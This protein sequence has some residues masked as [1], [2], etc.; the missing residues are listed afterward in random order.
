M[1]FQLSGTLEAYVEA[2]DYLDND[3]I[4]ENG[5]PIGFYDANNNS[6][7]DN[8]LNLRGGRTITNA[9]IALFFKQDETSFSSLFSIYKN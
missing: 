5:E 2:F 8:M 7:L 1:Q 4:I 6:Q 9:N 3:G